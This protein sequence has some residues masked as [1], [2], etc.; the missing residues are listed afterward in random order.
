[1]I[2]I[3]ML[4]EFKITAVNKTISDQKNHSKKLW[5]LLEYLITY[6]NKEIPQS[7]LIH[8]L[9]NGNESTNPTGAL[10]TLMH[11]VR[12]LLKELNYPHELILQR[13]GTY[14]WNPNIPCTVDIDVFETLCQEG[15]YISDPQLR[16]EKY[17]KAIV[18]YKNDFLPK[19]NCESWVTPVCSY[20][21]TMY[22]KIVHESIDILI[23]EQD[24]ANV[25]NICWK[26]LSIAPYEESLHYSLIQSLFLSGNQR[27][28]IKQYCSTT[29]LLFS[30]YGISPSPKLK[31]LYREIMKTQKNIETDLESIKENLKESQQKKGT[32]FCEYEFFK[33]IY[34]LE[35][36][37]AKRTGISIYLCLITLT[38]PNGD[39]PDLIVLNQ[40][41]NKL[42]DSIYESLRSSDV[43]SRY[44]ASQYIL[45]LPTSSEESVKIAL[46]RVISLFEKRIPK[47]HIKLNY[48]IT[49]LEP[50]KP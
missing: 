16:L 1:M 15:S 21:H 2:H 19:T 40:A 33:E 38:A 45:M 6:R 22:L 48:T 9:W 29:E 11:R 49:P 12:N 23:H 10:K 39:T 36:R 47:N 32:F 31:A 41:M 18:I 25:A 37:F 27:A 5:N 13:R 14:S 20:Y 50:A 24:Y 46:N 42:K 8:L 44:S 7:E 3:Q 17:R 28:A 26:S 43:F 30:K 34:R 35:A 4:G